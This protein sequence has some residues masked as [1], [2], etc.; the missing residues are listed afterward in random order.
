VPVAVRDNDLAAELL[1]ANPFG[2]AAGL[3]IARRMPGWRALQAHYQR[4]VGIRIWV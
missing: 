2:Q 1:G 4:G 3:F